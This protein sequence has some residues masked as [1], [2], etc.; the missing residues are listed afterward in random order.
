MGIEPNLLPRLFE[1][2]SQAKLSIMRLHGGT[3]L[4]LAIVSRLVS[5]MGGRVLVE[6]TLGEGSSF[7]AQIALAIAPPDAE[8]VLPGTAHQIKPSI[9]LPLPPFPTLPPSP[10]LQSPPVPSPRSSSEVDAAL[11]PSSTSHASAWPS[12]LSTS[13]RS[14]TMFIPGAVSDSPSLTGRLLGDDTSTPPTT[15]TTINI[16][17]MRENNDKDPAPPNSNGGDQNAP[18]ISSV[19]IGEVDEATQ[20]NAPSLN[21]GRSAVSTSSSSSSRARGA[22]RSRPGIG[23][24]SEGEAVSPRSATDT[25]SAPTSVPSAMSRR[26]RSSAAASVDMAALA[27]QK[28]GARLLLIVDDAPVNVKILVKMLHGLDCVTATN[29]VEAVEAVKKL[30]IGAHGPNARR[31]FDVILT[32]VI[33]PVMDGIQAA[34][35]IRAFEHEHQLP[36]VPIVAITGMLPLLLLPSCLL[37][38]SQLYTCVCVCM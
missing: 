10:P 24:G 35:V 18:S 2:Y 5:M 9:P 3:G 8:L 22:V 28:Y 38:P 13:S 6:S 31:Q 20:S 25:S 15:T 29:G 27:T 23:I 16:H 4:G 14:T 12:T 19:S 30:A 37:L 17:G 11:V 26:P 32:D 36:P 1:P 7:I 21:V 33:M 34:K